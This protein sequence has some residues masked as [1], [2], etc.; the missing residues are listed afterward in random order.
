MKRRI[1]V[2][3]ERIRRIVVRQTRSPTSWADPFSE[4]TGGAESEPPLITIIPRQPSLPSVA[5]VTDST[6]KGE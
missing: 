2:T 6:N 4:E 5:D 3:V 1:T